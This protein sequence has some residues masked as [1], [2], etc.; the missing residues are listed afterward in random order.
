MALAEKF[1]DFEF[2]AWNSHLTGRS[3]NQLL[4]DIMRGSSP[5]SGN[6]AT[7]FCV[8]LTRGLIKVLFARVWSAVI[9]SQC[10]STVHQWFTMAMKATETKKKSGKRCVAWGCSTTGAMEMVSI[11]LFPKDKGKCRFTLRLLYDF[12]DPPEI[13]S[14]PMACWCYGIVSLILLL[15]TDLAVVP[16]SLALPGILAL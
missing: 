16:L 6:T 12:F 9:N 14:F 4:R 11:H 2:D 3:Q 7:T 1:V 5:E 8:T 15:N 13:P 10:T